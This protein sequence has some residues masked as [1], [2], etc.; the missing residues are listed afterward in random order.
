[1]GQ[2]CGPA[3]QHPVLL[4]CIISHLSW[5]IC[6]FGG[7]LTL[8][9]W[10]LLIPGGQTHLLMLGLSRCFVLDGRTAVCGSGV[11]RGLQGGRLPATAAR[12]AA[13]SL[14]S[15]HVHNSLLGCLGAGWAG[16]RAASVCRGW[17][18]QCHQVVASPV[19]LL[20]T[21]FLFSPSSQGVPRQERPSPWCPFLSS[22][23]SRRPP[24][25]ARSTWACTLTW[26]LHRAAVR[27][28]GTEAGVRP[29][30]LLVVSRLF[31]LL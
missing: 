28:A 14:G 4:G 1:M 23:S 5:F 26:G 30:P 16:L 20:F 10:K 2:S 17:A 9:I 3:S 6:C 24:R 29:E 27:R 21:R 8:Q 31:P 18:A 12:T 11:S 19:Q 7:R 25:P 15:S 13:L 22:T